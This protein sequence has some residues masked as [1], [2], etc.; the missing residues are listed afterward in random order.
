MKHIDTAYRLAQQA[1][2]VA[3]SQATD[4]EVILIPVWYVEWRETADQPDMQQVH[5]RL[6]TPMQPSLSA[7]GSTPAIP[8]YP[9]IEQYM[10]S[11]SLPGLWAGTFAPDQRPPL[12]E[13]VHRS[14]HLD[15]VQLR[16]LAVSPAESTAGR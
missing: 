4:A 14:I 15:E 11:V 1:L 16:P 9:A 5:Y 12:A 7:G 8:L 10:Q 13:A 2:K 6:T 3:V